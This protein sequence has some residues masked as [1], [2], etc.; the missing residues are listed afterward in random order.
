MKEKLNKKQQKKLE[1]LFRKKKVL[2]NNEY[3]IIK[4]LKTVQDSLEHIRL[5]ID[6]IEIENKYG[7]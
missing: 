3:L 7:N 1:V 6:E 2:L 5:K 4:T